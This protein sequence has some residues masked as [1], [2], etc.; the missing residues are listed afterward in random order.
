MSQVIGKG[1]I[2]VLTPKVL[3]DSEQQPNDEVAADQPGFNG[4]IH[5]F[6]PKCILSKQ[7]K[8]PKKNHHS[9]K[10]QTQKAD[11]GDDADSSCNKS[12]ELLLHALQTT[13]HHVVLKRFTLV[14]G[15]E[16]VF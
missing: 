4:C 15:V 2:A 11:H 13:L 6:L 10:G 12:H 9:N 5:L 3:I 1:F 16:I 14:K 7:E 8:Q